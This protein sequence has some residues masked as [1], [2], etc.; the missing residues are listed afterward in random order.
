MAK[1]N[2][3]WKW[4]KQIHQCCDSHIFCDSH[5]FTLKNGV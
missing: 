5:A 1:K 2:I 3:N 4:K